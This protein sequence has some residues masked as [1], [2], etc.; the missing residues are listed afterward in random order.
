M[1][2]HIIRQDITKLECD[3]IVNAANN[4]LL[5]GGGVDG[6]IH[7]VAGGG[8]LEECKTLGGCNTPSESAYTGVQAYRYLDTYGKYRTLVYTDG[9][10]R[11]AENAGADSS[12]R[13]HFIPIWLDNGEYTVSVM[14]E[15]V[16][17][18]AGKV[19]AVRNS[20][21]ISIDGTIYDDW[22]QR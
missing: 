18:P 1:P 10:W 6:A 15:E 5:G 2:L 17:T 7:K 22:Y 4:T 9:A 20:A 11:F 16:W 13:V 19:S 8:L 12:E 3:A 14:A 21:P